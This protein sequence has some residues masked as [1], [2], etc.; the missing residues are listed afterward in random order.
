MLSLFC[1]EGI[2][3]KRGAGG[4]S[5]QLSAYF[6]RPNGIKVFQNTVPLDG[7]ERGMMKR[8]LDYYSH[9]R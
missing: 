8:L 4:K 5:F 7:G 2:N 9:S 3:Q 6:F 1:Y